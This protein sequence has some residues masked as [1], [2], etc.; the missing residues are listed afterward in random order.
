LELTR[1]RGAEGGGRLEN[2][3]SSGMVLASD[4]SGRVSMGEPAGLCIDASGDAT[5]ANEQN[6][7]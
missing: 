4:G 6:V 2:G 3:F 7:E 1:E 5:A